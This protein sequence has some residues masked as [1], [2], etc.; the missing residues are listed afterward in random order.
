MRGLK[1]VGEAVADHYTLH[2]GLDLTAAEVVVTSGAPEA[3]AASL[4]AL[5][6]P[7]D[8]VVLF[9]PVYDA[10]L[11]LLLRAGATARFVRLAPPA[12]RLTEAALEAAFTERTRLVVLNNPHNPVA[13]MFD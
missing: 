13:R 1:G 3:L 9:E 7:G 6:S 8:E 12:W 4:L 5:L 11:P 10:Y 2:Q